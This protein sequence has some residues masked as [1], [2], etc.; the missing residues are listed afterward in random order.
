MWKSTGRLLLFVVVLLAPVV[1]AADT[2]VVLVR[3]AEK[4]KGDDPPLTDAGSAR[5]RAL[6]DVLAHARVTLVLSTQF[7]RTRETAAPTAGAFDIPITITEATRDLDAHYEDVARAVR[8]APDGT[9]VLVVGHSNTV[10]GIIRALGGPELG[11]LDESEYDSLFMLILPEDGEP[12]F[13]HTRYGAP[14]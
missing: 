9:T 3:H 2:V 7:N 12:R 10:P 4:A 13:V 6:A 11:D 8:N 5:A 1:C 14:D